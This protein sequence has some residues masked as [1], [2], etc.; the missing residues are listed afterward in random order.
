M[1]DCLVPGCERTAV[2]GDDWSVEDAVEPLVAYRLGIELRL[3]VADIAVRL[4][5]CQQHADEVTDAAWQTVEARLREWGWK[6]LGR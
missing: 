2:R 5:L 3:S 1:R 6:P 4:S